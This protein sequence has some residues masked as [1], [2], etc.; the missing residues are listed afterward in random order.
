MK[1]LLNLLAETHGPSTSLRVLALFD[2]DF[3]KEL[4]VK[5]IDTGK[6]LDGKKVLPEITQRQSSQNIIDDESGEFEQEKVEVYNLDV[7]FDDAPALNDGVLK[8]MKDCTT[9]TAI[10]YTIEL[11]PPT[12]KT[13]VIPYEV[14]EIKESKE[15]PEEAEKLEMNEKGENNLIQWRGKL[16]ELEIKQE[17]TVRVNTVANGKTLS[18]KVIHLDPIKSKNE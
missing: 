1:L 16:E 9:D 7:Y 8:V 15:A 4:K 17:Y 6:K 11:F 2:V 10:M 3:N 5:T 14:P 12:K 18:S 13:S